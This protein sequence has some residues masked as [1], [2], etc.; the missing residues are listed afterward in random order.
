MSSRTLLCF[1]VAFLFLDFDAFLGAIAD[2]LISHKN[3]ETVFNESS[4]FF[5]VAI[6]VLM[7]D[8][9]T[10]YHACVDD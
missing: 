2:Y 8:D 7:H 6:L 4:I 3:I 5:T 1:F 9:G 10:E